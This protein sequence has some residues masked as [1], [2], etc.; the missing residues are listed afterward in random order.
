MSLKNLSECIHIPQTAVSYFNHTFSRIDPSWQSFRYWAAIHNTI[1]CLMIV[2]DSSHEGTL[3]IK[4]FQSLQVGEFKCSFIYKI[5]KKPRSANFT[6]FFGSPKF[7]WVLLD[8]WL[9]Y[10]LF[11]DSWSEFEG[12]D[13][14]CQCL[15]FCKN[16]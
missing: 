14:K 16:T 13:K 11:V 12:F 8:G 4:E 5:S 3:K 6:T 10:T 1:T 9:V 7:L 2:R 15:D